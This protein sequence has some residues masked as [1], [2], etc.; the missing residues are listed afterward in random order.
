MNKKIQTL[1]LGGLLLLGAAASLRA[2]ALYQ[3]KEMDQ[4]FRAKAA[5][6]AGDWPA[7]RSGMDAYLKDFPAGKMRDE[8][9]FW[10]AGSLDRLARDA[11]DVATAADLKKKAF[12]LLGR[13]IKEFPA[14]LWGDDARET[15]ITI[16]GGL[17]VLGDEG[18]QK[19]LEESV[20]SKAKNGLEIKKAALNSIIA[21][22][23]GTALP[24][25]RNFLSTESEADLRLSAV[26][27]IGAKYRG[28]AVPILEG[29]ARND[30]DPGVRSEA[31]SLLAGIRMS[32]IPVKISYAC[33]ETRLTDPSV[34]AKVPEGT[35]ARF[36]VP[37]GSSGSEAKMKKAIGRLFDGR[38][39][40]AVS[41]ATMDSD[42]LD[43]LGRSRIA[44]T[45]A[46]FHIELIADS[47]AKTINEIS[48]RVRFGEMEAPFSADLANDAVLAARR[49]DRQAVMILHMSPK[50]IDENA[51]EAEKSPR[52][53]TRDFLKPPTYRNAYRTMGIVVYS[54]RDI[55]VFD[56]SSFQSNLFD[57]GQA[58]AEMPGPGGTW[59]LSGQLILLN[60][61]RVLVGRMAK[62]VRPDGT[63][64][65]AGDEIQVPVANPEGFRTGKGAVAPASGVKV[66]L[67]TYPLD[68]GGRIESS[69][70]RIDAA[71]TSDGLIDFEDS[72]AILPGPKGN[73][74][75]E[76]R[77]VLLPSSGE[78]LAYK[79]ALKDAEGKT[80]AE[81]ELLFVPV[82]NPEN[83]RLVVK[84]I[85]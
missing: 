73:W 51:V 70:P 65:S 15:Q 83:Y 57:Y 4:F 14:S 16:A 22:N 39:E 10:L 64:A 72:R 53:P 54:D 3:N 34:Y 63:T 36:A 19:F 5:V 58:V 45:I 76:G 55:D 29:V 27:L 47:I 52:R 59:V 44:H 49:G 17:A 46:A 61:E 66:E 37:S 38:I 6:F 25:L 56:R 43:L 20:Q 31:E 8:A 79:A 7:V 48:G 30:K 81:G 35:V 85:S 33:F 69:R 26:R 32:L 82:R 23:P 71:K 13:L 12:D 80:V 28:E 18:E 67:S 60:K 84:N 1:I 68:G 74:V 41:K 62:L 50:E 40:F 9:L 42:V 24:V 78:I 77:L 75:L 21:L 11:R 2:D